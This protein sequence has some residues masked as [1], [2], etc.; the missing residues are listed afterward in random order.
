MDRLNRQITILSVVL[1]A[2]VG[3]LVLDWDRAEKSADVDKEAPPSRLLFDFKPESITRVTLTGPDGKIQFDS[4]EGTWQ[5]VSPVTTIAEGSSISG[6]LERFEDLRIGETAL[7]GSPADYGLGED[8]RIELRLEQVDGKAF[9]VLIGEDT[10]VG[11]KTY[12]QVPGDAAV[13]PLSSQ[14]RE[15]VEKTPDDFRG[16]DVL[17]ISPGSVERVRIVQG[18]REVVYRKDETGWWL[19]DT[20]PRASDKEI[21]DYLGL[22]SE[23]KVESFL[24]GKTPAELGLDNPAATVSIKDASGTRS[25]RIGIPD[26]NGAVAAVG[27]IAV[28][29]SALDLSVL[30]PSEDWP[31]ALLVEAK[32]WKVDAI[33]VELGGK[34]LELSR[35][36][37]SWKDKEGK[38]APAGSAVVEALLGLAVDRTATP[39]MA[40]EGGRVVIGL[41]ESRV[42]VKIGD[43]DKNGARV[44]RDEAGGPAFLIPAESLKT[45]EDAVEGRTEAAPSAGGGHGADGEMPDGLEELLRGMGA[46]QPH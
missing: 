5:M 37:G 42:T 38:D 16:R 19:G 7:K 33:T 30:L 24:D 11:F 6:L 31:S 35:K 17:D 3:F 22:V 1:L 34:K 10:P 36:A 29:I 14:G 32:S 40:G 39:T 44:A 43:P 8:K 21:G 18:T 23:M 2:I 12:A 45:L 27:E 41:G 4:V 13:Y 15:M 26:T 25:V 20:G 46:E 9:T 28:R